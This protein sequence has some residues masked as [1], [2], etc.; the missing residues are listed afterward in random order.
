MIPIIHKIIARL[1]IP[2]A[3]KELG[4]VSAKNI[5]QTNIADRIVQG[6]SIW[7]QKHFHCPNTIKKK[8]L[9]DNGRLAAIVKTTHNARNLN[10][11]LSRLPLHIKISQNFNNLFVNYVT[12]R[13]ID[14]F[15]YFQTIKLSSA[16]WAISRYKKKRKGSDIFLLEHRHLLFPLNIVG[17]NPSVWWL[18]RTKLLKF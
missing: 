3:S 6:M 9:I 14:L 4:L 1:T 16:I 2:T 13:T 12:L 10:S 11:I 7:K 18:K 8:S 5:I 17:E 15:D